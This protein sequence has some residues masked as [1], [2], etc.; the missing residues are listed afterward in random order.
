MPEYFEKE[1]LKTWVKEFIT[2]NPLLLKALDY[3]PSADVEPVRHGHWEADVC[4]RMS[5]AGKFESLVC[6]KCNKYEAIDIIDDYQLGFN[7]GNAV[8]YILRAGKKGDALEDLKKAKWYIEHEICKLMNEQE[9]KKEKNSDFHACY[10]CNKCFKSECVFQPW[11]NWKNDPTLLT[12]TT[13]GAWEA[14]K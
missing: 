6:Y 9:E 1:I 4:G 13:C 10:Q 12:K 3:T 8:K 14:K 7:L 11:K 2:T 5:M